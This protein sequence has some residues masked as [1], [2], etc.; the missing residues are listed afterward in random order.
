MLVVMVSDCHRVTCCYGDNNIA[1]LLEILDELAK[2][3]LSCFYE[4]LQEKGK[5]QIR[6]TGLRIDCVTSL[7]S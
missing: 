6:E 1:R 2:S 4:V 5:E 7:I 3:N